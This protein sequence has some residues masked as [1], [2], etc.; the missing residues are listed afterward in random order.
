MLSST[1]RSF[2]D[3]PHTAVVGEPGTAIINLADSRAENARKHIVEMTKEDPREVVQAAR[4]VSLG[5]YHDIRAKDVDLKRLGAVLA[6]SH[7][8]E[9]NNFED[10][11]LL[12]GIG[13]RTLRSLALTSE[14]IHGDASRFD[15]PARFRGPKGGKDRAK[16]GPR[17]PK[18]APRRSKVAPRW[19]QEGPRGGKFGR[20]GA[21][22][23]QLRNGL[24]A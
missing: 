10:L 8:E 17:G 1:V 12:K 14:L 4:S 11:L 6:M 3:D 15:D 9:I 13:P 19:C 22:R 18:V 2:V 5:D 23:F 24:T 21:Q 20:L 7:G 16:G